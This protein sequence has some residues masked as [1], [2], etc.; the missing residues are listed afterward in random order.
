MGSG[1]GRGVWL[2]IQ[3]TNSLCWLHQCLWCLSHPWIRPSC[4][5]ML[6]L[7]GRCGGVQPVGSV[8][9]AFGMVHLPGSV[10]VRSSG[11]K[12]KLQW[13]SQPMRVLSSRFHRSKVPLSGCPTEKRMSPVSGQPFQICMA[14]SFHTGRRQGVEG[15]QEEEVG[16]KERKPGRGSPPGDACMSWVRLSSRRCLSYMA[17]F[18]LWEHLLSFISVS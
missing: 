7:S 14:P 2:E 10:S 6:Q 11:P 3:C 15:Q 18:S 8:P 1:G 9:Y 13:H 16:R 5:E 17:S 4:L 12:S